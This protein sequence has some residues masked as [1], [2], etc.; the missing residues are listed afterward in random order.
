MKSYRK[1]R[2]L[3]QSIEVYKHNSAIYKSVLKQLGCDKKNVWRLTNGHTLWNMVLRL[4]MIARIRRKK[5]RTILKSLKS[6]NLACK[7]YNKQVDD[8]LYNC[9]GITV[10][11]ATRFKLDTMFP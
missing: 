8:L 2:G 10:P 1:D 9:S 4:F 6:G 5:Q 3:S 11:A 7:S